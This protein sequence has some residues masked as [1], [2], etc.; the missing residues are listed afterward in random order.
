LREEKKKK[1]DGRG[2]KGKSRGVASE[3]GKTSKTGGPM[4]ARGD[5]EK[6]SIENV[7]E[8]W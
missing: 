8:G 6:W 2:V 7:S 5:P 4:L 1:R 3:E